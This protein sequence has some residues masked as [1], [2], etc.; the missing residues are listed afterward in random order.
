VTTFI[1][2]NPTARKHH[3]C[4][5]CGRWIRPGERYRRTFAKDC[6]D[7]WTYVECPHC[8]TLVPLIQWED[9]YTLDDFDSWEPRTIAD[10]RLKALWRK[11]WERADG[12]LYPVPA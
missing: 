5:D 11:R 1:S 6:G 4:E 8:I 7:V 12:T 10:L 9:T 3:L 2:S